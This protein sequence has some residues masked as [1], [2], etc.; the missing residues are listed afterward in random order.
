MAKK[1]ETPLPEAAGAGHLE[2]SIAASGRTFTPD[3]RRMQL[4]LSAAA[5]REAEARARRRRTAMVQAKKVLRTGG[6]LLHVAESSAEQRLN[7]RQV[8]KGRAFLSVWLRDGME[9]TL[10]KNHFEVGRSRP[11]PPRGAGW[12]FHRDDHG[13]SAWRRPVREGG[14]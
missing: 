8:W 6:Y 5:Q 1:I 9:E 4:P 14:R 2:R 13:S 12:E 10:T 11:V 3:F 7:L